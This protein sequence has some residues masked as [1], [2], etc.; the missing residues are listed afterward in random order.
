MVTINPQTRGKLLLAADLA[1]GIGLAALVAGMIFAPLEGAAWPASPERAPLAIQRARPL[2]P[3]SSFDAVCRRDLRC[4]LIQNT[5][6]TGTQA[7]KFTAVLI[8][9]ALDPGF[10]C[11]FFRLANGQTQTVQVGQKIEDAEV[12]EISEGAVKVRLAGQVIALTVDK[13][14]GQP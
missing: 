2:E 13:K 10:V 14:E 9:T 1:L 3:L 4:T 7:P 6:G 11:A 8:G 12:A 5:P